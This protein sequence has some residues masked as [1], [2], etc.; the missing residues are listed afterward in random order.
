MFCFNFFA[1]GVPAK[2]YMWTG[3]RLEVEGNTVR[4]FC[5]TSGYPM[6]L[7]IWVG[8][9]DQILN[10]NEKYQ[11]CTFAQRRRHI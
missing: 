5:R 8:P 11:V 1:A 4:L 6:P 7:V 10:D 3:N 9:E 2:I